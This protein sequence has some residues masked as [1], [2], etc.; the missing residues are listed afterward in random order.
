MQGLDMVGMMLYKRFF[1]HWANIY[2]PKM[3]QDK[4]IFDKDYVPICATWL[5]LKPFAQESRIREQL[6]SMNDLVERRL[7]RDWQL[8]RGKEGQFKV[9]AFPGTGFFKD[10]E[11]MY[12]RKQA[13][14]TPQGDAREPLVY[15]HDFHMALG[16]DQDAF[17]PKEVAYARELLERYGNAAVRELMHFGLSEARKT[18]FDMQWFGALSLYEGKWQA[19]HQKK[20]RA[21]E[22]QAA[23][24]ACPYCDERGL[25]ETEEG[26]A[27]YCPHDREKIACFH[28][29]KA[30]RG[31]VQG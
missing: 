24:V 10:Y 18:N 19:A 11:N 22:R 8:T 15:L 25:L 9:V 26:T 7:L 27:L 29:Q 1:R 2:H 14:S 17:A 21:Q 16:H 3:A 28:A 4:L 5:N 23:I 31:Y 13:V 30:I 6:R 20:R 12:T